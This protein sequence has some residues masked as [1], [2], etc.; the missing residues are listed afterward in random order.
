MNKQ[1]WLDYFSNLHKN[2]DLN[3]VDE[4]AR[5]N[6]IEMKHREVLPAFFTGDIASKNKIVTISLN[7][8]FQE[9]T[10]YKTNKKIKSRSTRLEQ[11]LP[12]E[13]SNI[14]EED[15]SEWFNI[16]LDR[17]NYYLP[18]EKLHSVFTYLYKCFVPN[19]EWNANRG[20]KLGWL[21]NNMVNLDWCPYYSSQTPTFQV[22]GS[23]S[24]L[25]NDNMKFI[26]KEINPRLVFIHGAPYRNLVENNSDINFDQPRIFDDLIARKRNNIK[27]YK[28]NE[29]FGIKVP[30]Y[31]MS[32]SINEANLSANALRIYKHLKEQGLVD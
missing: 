9:I 14:Q 20:K 11:N 28:G 7:P 5:V 22:N 3:L 1:Q 29:F 31:Y 27:L 23:V 30:V 21:T 18:T 4:F 15:F 12:T 24:E 17:Y 10:M 16:C 25:W 32:N 2:T 13:I 8:K 19:S 6:G 26:I